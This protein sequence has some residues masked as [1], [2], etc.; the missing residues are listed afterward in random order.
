[1]KAFDASP[2]RGSLDV[3]LVLDLLLVERAM[4]SL[5]LL[6]L[7][8]DVSVSSVLGGGSEEDVLE[9]TKRETMGRE[10]RSASK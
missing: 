3:L 4:L 10:E 6:V 9:E 8:S 1:M 7:S 5:L 2:A